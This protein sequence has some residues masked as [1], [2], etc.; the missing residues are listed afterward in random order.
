MVG[1]Q[2]LRYIF[3]AHTT[4]KKKLSR[5]VIMIDLCEA[6][7]HKRNTPWLQEAVV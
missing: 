4:N 6:K 5:A 3:V 7:E 1:S 2:M